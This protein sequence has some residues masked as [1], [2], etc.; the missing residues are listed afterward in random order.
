GAGAGSFGFASPAQEYS[1]ALVTA[2]QASHA[3]CQTAIG[4]SGPAP[5]QH[6]QSESLDMLH[7]LLS[8]WI[9]ADQNLSEPRMVLIRNNGREIGP[10]HAK[11]TYCN[12]GCS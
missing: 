3:L 1:A 2:T 10:D 5:V 8:R 12:P 4:F 9:I 6:I 7:A 11:K